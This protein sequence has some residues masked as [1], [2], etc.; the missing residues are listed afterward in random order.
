[1]NININKIANHSFFFC[2]YLV[3]TE[4]DYLRDI[5]LEL[6]IRNELLL[7]RLSD[8]RAALSKLDK[9]HRRFK[10]NHSDCHKRIILYR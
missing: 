1:M 10:A 2:F 7:E 8:S 9:E 5:I 3:C 4:E 6:E